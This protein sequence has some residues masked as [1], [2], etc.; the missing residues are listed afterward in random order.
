M[1][2]PLAAIATDKACH[3]SWGGFTDSAL[4]LGAAAAP[5][6]GTTRTPDCGDDS[7]AAAAAPAAATPGRKRAETIAGGT[8]H[9]EG[10]ED[11]LPSPAGCPAGATAS[12]AAAAGGAV[13]AAA[14]AI[15]GGAKG[16]G[17]GDSCLSLGGAA[18]CQAKGFTAISFR[19]NLGTP[20][21]SAATPTVARAPRAVLPPTDRGIVVA[22]AAA[23]AAESG[24]ARRGL[25]CGEA[26]IP[27]KG[28]GLPRPP[29][30]AAGAVSGEAMAGLH[31]KESQEG[32]A[33]PSAPGEV[34]LPLRQI[35]DTAAAVPRNPARTGEA[36]RRILSGDAWRSCG[37]PEVPGSLDAKDIAAA[38]G[39]DGAKS[40]GAVRVGGDWDLTPLAANTGLP[41]RAEGTAAA[42]V[43][44]GTAANVGRG[45]GAG[46]GWP[47]RGDSCCA[48]P[49]GN[50]DIVAVSAGAPV[51]T[52]ATAA[53]AEWAHD[54]CRETVEPPGCCCAAAK[55]MLLY[56]RCI[57]DAASDCCRETADAAVTAALAHS[58]GIAAT[59]AAWSKRGEPHAWP[60]IC[61]GKTCLVAGTGDAQ[62]LSCCCCRGDSCQVK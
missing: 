34:G 21:A 39:G 42:P 13:A 44:K 40:A 60:G 58:G 26:V 10:A 50:E 3:V 27:R 54:A 57:V 6:G 51:A 43:P 52:A 47:G 53:A 8:L 45:G 12:S 36:W 55:L 35:G 17:S 25:A 22:V 38:G 29:K 59:E 9:E 14:G 18:G 16:C 4:R 15:A 1:A 7:C 5:G 48:N 32:T 56:E 24:D 33:A 11:G 41:G 62:A 49:P 19:G 2:E 46:H 61:W 30:P 31:S 37:T 23:A 28:T 20:A